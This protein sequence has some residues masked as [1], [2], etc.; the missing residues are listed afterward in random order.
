MVSDRMPARFGA[1]TPGALP[2]PAPTPGLGRCPHPRR[3]VA[4]GSSTTLVGLALKPGQL[5][6]GVREGDIVDLGPGPSK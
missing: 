6:Q 3:A 1:A 5:P 2:P 4:G